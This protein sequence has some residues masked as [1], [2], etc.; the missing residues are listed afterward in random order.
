MENKETKTK[1]VLYRV[2]YTE[3]ESKRRMS[4]DVFALDVEAAKQKA[5]LSLFDGTHFISP[6]SNLSVSV[7]LLPTY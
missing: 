6:K 5:K 1:E 3:K 2:T 4:I 7:K